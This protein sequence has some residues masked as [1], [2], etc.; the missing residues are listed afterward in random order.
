VLV[1]LSKLEPL[2]FHLDGEKRLLGSNTGRHLQVFQDGPLDDL[3]GNRT[4][5]RHTVL[6]VGRCHLWK[7]QSLALQDF[8]QHPGHLFG[9]ARTHFVLWND[10]LWKA[11]R[12]CPETANG[13]PVPLR[14]FRHGHSV[15]LPG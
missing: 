13:L 9:F 14:N 6:Q 8:L 4:K 3:L 7:F 1:S 12:L 15:L 11:L 5:L 2:S 10:K